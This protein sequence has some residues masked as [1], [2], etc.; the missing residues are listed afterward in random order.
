MRIPRILGPENRPLNHYHVMS[1]AIE[2]RM[3]FDDVAKEK[4]R[5]LLDAHL[6]F[7]QIRC[8][9]FCIMGNHFHL[10]LEVPNS[11]DNPLQHASDAEFLDHLEILYNEDT[12]TRIATQLETYRQ[13][14]LEQRAEQLRQ[15]Y[16]DRM[17]DL[18][19]FMRELKQRFTQ[20]HN[21][22]TERRGPLW[23][24]RYKSVLVENSET[25]LRTM[26][27]YIDLNPVRANLVRDPKDYRWCGYAEAVAGKTTA[28]EGLS[29]LVINELPGDD[30][31]M[32]DPAWPEIQRI[33]RCWLYEEGE[34]Q[35]DETGRVRRRGF[36]SE[37]T[38]TVTERQQ[39]ALARR[40]LVRAQVRYFTDGLALGSKAFLEEVFQS[41]R[42]RF[43][44]KRVDGSRKM[45]NINW[46]ALRSMRDLRGC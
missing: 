46:G 12:V 10:L 25:A 16:I 27:A 8:I 26:A 30:C 18:S 13:G 39:G 17:C 32:T 6:R 9:T 43:S 44:P 7:A 15:L 20:W 23:Q 41:N 1:R 11:E 14:G 24:D 5:A 31:K 36:S 35:V 37:L 28:R 21:R 45:R 4:F 3:I 2:G 33:Y 34:E 42:N 38:A 40:V 19:A 22:R 29:A